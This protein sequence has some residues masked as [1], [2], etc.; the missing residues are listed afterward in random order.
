M[1]PMYAS[2]GHPWVRMCMVFLLYLL[3]LWERWKTEERWKRINHHRLLQKTSCATVECI[4]RIVVVSYI[5][6]H[7]HGMHG[8]YT[9]IPCIYAHTCVLFFLKRTYHTAATGASS[10]MKKAAGLRFN[11]ARAVGWCRRTLIE[12]GRFHFVVELLSTVVVVYCSRS[13]WTFRFS[14]LFLDDNYDGVILDS[15]RGRRKTSRGTRWDSLPSRS[16]CYRLSLIIIA[17]QDERR[18]LYVA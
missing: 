1:R 7:H 14:P 6:C 3:T 8:S 16:S 2:A 11:V 12:L 15:G 4:R 10:S 13:R 18:W 5:T 17:L 9:F